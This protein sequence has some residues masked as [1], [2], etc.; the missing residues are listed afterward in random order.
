MKKK[1]IKKWETF[2][3]T[4]SE[5]MAENMPKVFRYYFYKNNFLVEGDFEI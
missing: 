4:S 5:F 3:E 2:V 1:F